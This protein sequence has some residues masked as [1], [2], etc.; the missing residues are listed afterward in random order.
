[1]Q[2]DSNSAERLLNEA[3]DMLQK[4]LARETIAIAP[5]GVIS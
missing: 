5:I 4:A 2:R 3:R 1:M